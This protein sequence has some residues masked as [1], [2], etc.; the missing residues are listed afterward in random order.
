[1][2]AAVSAAFAF[3]VDLLVEVRPPSG[4]MLTSYSMSPRILSG[5]LPVL[6]QENEHGQKMAPRE[7]TGEQAVGEGVEHRRV[8]D[9]RER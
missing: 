4:L 3:E 7:T 1:M 9:A 5:R 6:A 8:G 2:R